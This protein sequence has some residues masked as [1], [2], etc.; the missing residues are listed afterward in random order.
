MNINDKTDVKVKLTDLSDYELAQKAA[1][2]D[3]AAFEQIYWQH[4]RR[5][6]SVCLRMTKN[7]TEAEDVTQQ[8]F[9]LLFRK[10]GS[11]RGDS[12]FSTWLHRMTVNTTLMHFRKNRTI[13]E[14]TTEDGELPEGI[15]SGSRKHSKTHFVD[16]IAFTRAIGE[17]PDGYRKVFILHDIQGYEHKEIA[18]MLGCAAGTS[19]SQLYKAR[20]K[21]QKLMTAEN[22]FPIQTL[23]E[24][25]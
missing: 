18:Q 23:S 5:V 17:L 7:V 25:F 21:L 8:V 12:A 24:E 10:I 16:S 6:F 13:K 22:K 2:G 20:R 15:Y 14:S 11:F 1:D 19:K 3:V 4:H 9:L